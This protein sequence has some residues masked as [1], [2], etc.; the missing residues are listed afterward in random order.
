MKNIDPQHTKA[1][2][3]VG[4]AA[5]DQTEA[6]LLDDEAKSL[7]ANVAEHTGARETQRNQPSSQQNGLV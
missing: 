3:D 5:L 1:A 6:E 4:E 7:D 2:R